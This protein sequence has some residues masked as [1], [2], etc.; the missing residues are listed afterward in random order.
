MHAAMWIRVVYISNSTIISKRI[1]KHIM[2][3]RSG[4]K[5]YNVRLH[6]INPSNCLDIAYRIKGLYFVSIKH[7]MNVA[8]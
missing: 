2:C 4:T 1:P 6:L 5:D 8:S 3:R 7:A